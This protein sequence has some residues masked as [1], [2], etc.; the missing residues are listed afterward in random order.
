MKK[1]IVLWGVLLLCGCS[2]RISIEQQVLEELEHQQSAAGVTFTNM[3]KRYYSY[4]LPKDVGRIS[5]DE[6]SSVLIKDNTRFTMSL[7]TSK[8]IVSDYYHDPHAR[9]VP[10]EA[11]LVSSEEGVMR[12]NGWYKDFEGNHQKYDLTVSDFGK[13]YLMRL[14]AG[15]FD[16]YSIVTRAN[17]NSLLSSFF[18]IVR[19]SRVDDELVI[20]DF[21]LQNERNRNGDEVMNEEIVP[22]EGAIKDLVGK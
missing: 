12:F 22:E 15:N 6:L 16:F 5:S 14:E 17:M 8:L 2:S 1:L 20:N 9:V 21:S 18:T 11:S 3:D 4:Y 7:E 19:S 10:E 13:A